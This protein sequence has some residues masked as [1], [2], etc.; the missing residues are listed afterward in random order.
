MV[1]L[2]ILR[3]L[4]MEQAIG[5]GNLAISHGQDD[6]CCL[7]DAGLARDRRGT[8]L[9]FDDRADE[10]EPKAEAALGAALVATK[11]AVTE[12]REIF[13]QDSAAGV[14]EMDGDGVSARSAVMR[15]RPPAGV[16]LIALSSRL[17]KTRRSA[18]GSP[19]T[20]RPGGITV[21]TMTPFSSATFV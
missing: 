9:G 3:F 10:A 12:A 16:Y 1:P 21:V 20:H 13:G 11:E 15:A 5:R 6:D 17:A 14:G 4:R 19:L 8:T 2:T 18:A 7:A